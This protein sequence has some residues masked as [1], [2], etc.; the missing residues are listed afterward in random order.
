MNAAEWR[1]K[2]SWYCTCQHGSG[3]PPSWHMVKL[4]YRTR[5]SLFCSATLINHVYGWS[6][7][8]GG[9]AFTCLNSQD[10]TICLRQ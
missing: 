4:P 6:P 10:M 3:G 2:V 5:E 8:G 7:T 9:D 1:P